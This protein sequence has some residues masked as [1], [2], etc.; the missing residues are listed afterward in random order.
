MCSWRVD[1]CIWRGEA[2]PLLQVVPTKLEV[3][4]L[5]LWIGWMGRLVVQRA[6]NLVIF[7]RLRKFSDVSDGWQSNDL[8]ASRC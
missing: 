8:M 3:G 1:T 4:G 5:I 7:F 2:G 6:D